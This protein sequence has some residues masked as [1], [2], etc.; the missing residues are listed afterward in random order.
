MSLPAELEIV[1]RARHKAISDLLS[2]EA[3][4]VVADQKHLEQY[5]PERAYWHHGYRA[6]LQDLLDYAAQNRR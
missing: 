4:Y 1:V 3:P 5:S 6:A 2:D